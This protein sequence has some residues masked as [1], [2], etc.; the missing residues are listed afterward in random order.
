MKNLEGKV[1]FI[2]LVVAGTGLLLLA[3]VLYYY[4]IFPLS[5]ENFIPRKSGTE[6]RQL[7]NFME[8]SKEKGNSAEETD[9][10][11]E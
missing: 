1:F 3:L 8:N 6:I 7:I 10:N 4:V 2:A 9:N 5:S 11:S